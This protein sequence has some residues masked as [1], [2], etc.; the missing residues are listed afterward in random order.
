MRWGLRWPVESCVGVERERKR[1]LKLKCTRRKRR[2]GGCS[3]LRSLWRGSR[4]R[5]RPD[6]GG[7]MLRQRH[8]ARI[9][10]WSASDIGDGRARGEA[11]RER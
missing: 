4:R 7:G 8:G 10:T 5:R 1:K 11:R 2:Q 3:G 6:S 9:A